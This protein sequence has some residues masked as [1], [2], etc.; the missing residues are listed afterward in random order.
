M[1]L[2]VFVIRNILSSVAIGDFN[3]DGSLDVAVANS[4]DDTV[5]VLLGNGSGAL[6]P[7]GPAISVGRNPKSIRAGDFNDDGYSDLAVANYNDGTVTTLLNNKNGTFSASTI[8]AGSGAGSGPRAVAI[9]GSGTSLL[10]AVANFKDD[11]VSVLQSNGDGTFGAQTIVPV[12][13]GPVDVSWTDFNGDG[14]QDLVVANYTVGSLNIALGSTGGSYAVLG[15]FS[16]LGHAASAAVGD[17]DGDG[18]PDVVVSNYSKNQTEVFLS[19]A[20]I[21]VPYTAL[22]VPS[23]HTVEA[24]YT[25]DEASKYRSSSAPKRTSP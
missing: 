2:G 20:E 1:S 7:S 24:T 18:T 25:P 6:T 22:S 8:S 9:N 16:T 11:T 23:G 10:L 15:P 13:H 5:S 21:I 14:I 4:I 17:L 3:H 12:G 19:G